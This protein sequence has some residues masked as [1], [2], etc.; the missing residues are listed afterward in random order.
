MFSVE[1]YTAQQQFAINVFS[2]KQIVSRQSKFDGNMRSN[3]SFADEESIKIII[4]HVYDGSL[5]DQVSLHSPTQCYSPNVDGELVV[6]TN[7]P[8]S[9]S[10]STHMTGDGECQVPY[11]KMRQHYQQHLLAKR[12]PMQNNCTFNINCIAVQESLST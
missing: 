3:Q 7:W 1:V 10:C 4:E 6:T 9:W 12:T 5:D 2:S 8:F 11:T